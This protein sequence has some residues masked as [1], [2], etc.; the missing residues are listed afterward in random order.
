MSTEI[1]KFSQE[2]SKKFDI[3]VDELLNIW[4][5][6]SISGFNNKDI[7]DI[8]VIDDEDMEQDDVIKKKNNVCQ[9]EYVRSD[10]KGQ[11]CSEPPLD[12]GCF[13]KKHKGTKAA[14]G[15]KGSLKKI[16]TDSK[17]FNVVTTENTQH[18]NVV[19]PT[20]EEKRQGIT[21][22]MNYR[23]F[24]YLHVE[25]GLAFF[26]KEERVVFARH[27]KNLGKLV[28]LKEEDLLICQRY[29]FKTDPSKWTQYIVESVS[30]NDDDDNEEDD[31]AEENEENKERVDYDDE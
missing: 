27:D 3:P 18:T 7:K 8:I 13:C 9:Y 31:N 1:V 10:K 21:I 19:G 16:V 28:E 11:V 5:A 24:R 20:E 25:T 26:S 14:K 2:I 17:K 6:L 23:V 4:K 15:V 29:G 22:R 30:L 12:G